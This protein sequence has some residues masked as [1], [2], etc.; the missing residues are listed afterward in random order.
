MLVETVPRYSILSNCSPW[1]SV[2][3]FGSNGASPLSLATVR[4]RSWLAPRFMLVRLSRALL[5]PMPLSKLS[6][7]ALAISRFRIGWRRELFLASTISL[8]SSYPSL[9]CWWVC[10]WF[11]PRSRTCRRR[12]RGRSNDNQSSCRSCNGKNDSLPSTQA[13]STAQLHDNRQFALVW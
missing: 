4:Q 11:C 8:A 7:C 5:E 2:I 13:F 1:V 12:C 3:T 10:Q 9:G 6:N